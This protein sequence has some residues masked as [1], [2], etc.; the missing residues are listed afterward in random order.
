MDILRRIPRDL[1]CEYV[2]TY[3]GKPVSGIRGTIKKACEE[4]GVTFGQDAEGGVVIR[5]LRRTADTLMVRAGVQDVYR[6]TLLRHVQTGMDRHYVHP[7]LETDLR[8]AM[9]TYARWLKAELDA[10]KK[11][12]VAAC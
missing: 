4:A 5:D 7:D 9:A 10:Q 12:Q 6:R 8:P 3:R 1:R 11:G 2:F